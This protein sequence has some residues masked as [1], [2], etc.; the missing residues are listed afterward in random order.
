MRSADRARVPGHRDLGAP[1]CSSPAAVSP[2]PPRHPSSL[3]L[4]GI[5]ISAQGADDS[6]TLFEDLLEQ[7]MG[8]ASPQRETLPPH[9][10]AAL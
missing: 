3:L 4:A 2:S 1:E 10:T 8:L 5:R 7:V 6:L 9:S